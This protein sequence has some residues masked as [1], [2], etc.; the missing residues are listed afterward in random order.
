[1]RKIAILPNLFTAGSL[2][3]G[4]MAIFQVF[5]QGDWLTAVH[6]IFAAAFLDV[7]DGFVARLT[8]TQSAFGVNFDSLADVVSFGVAPACIVYTAVAPEYPLIAQATCGLFAVFAAVRLARFNVQQAKEEKK[9]FVGLPT[10][11]AALAAI[12][13]FWVLVNHPPLE[14]IVA[15]EKALPIA[16]ALLAFLMV[17]RFPFFGIKSVQVAKRHQEEVFVVVVIILFLL[18]LLKQHIDLIALAIF[19]PYALSGPALF[20][21]Q[22]WRPEPIPARAPKAG[23]P[24]RARAAGPP[25]APP[26]GS[27]PR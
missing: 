11:A 25:E 23:E 24:R 18:V 6:L 2:L 12:S 26:P 14:A 15:P 22:L 4:V 20:V 8:R 13:L 9:S 17:S 10:P 16:M 21:Y 1:M 27:S 19:G 3:C 7:F 5:D